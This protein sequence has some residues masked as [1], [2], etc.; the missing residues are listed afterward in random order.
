MTT[1]GYIF[2]RSKAEE[3]TLKQHGFLSVAERVP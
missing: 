2:A 3:Q 1:V